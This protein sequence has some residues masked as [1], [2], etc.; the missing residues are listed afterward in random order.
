LK[1]SDLRDLKLSSFLVYDCI[2][3]ILVVTMSNSTPTTKNSKPGW[4]RK[5]WTSVKSYFQRSKTAKP[6][7]PTDIPFA[8]SNMH[9]QVLQ[10][11]VVPPVDAVPPPKDIPEA[12][13]LTPKRVNDAVAENSLSDK[14]TPGDVINT[15]E[16]LVETASKETTPERPRRHRKQR[17]RIPEKPHK[18][19][20][21]PYNRQG[22]QRTSTRPNVAIESPSKRGN[23]SQ[24]STQIQ[25]GKGILSL[26]TGLLTGGAV[27]TVCLA[28]RAIYKRITTKS[29][30]NKKNERKNRQFNPAE[31]DNEVEARW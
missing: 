21:N 1:F 3:A 20:R 11:G 14:T 17:E 26:L 5:G 8:N 19:G 22:R 16:G 27:L 31:S 30:G 7:N 25:S 28:A 29:E 18:N 9:L 15:R 13:G 10:E 24:V 12:T 4:I 6:S 23:K 2:I